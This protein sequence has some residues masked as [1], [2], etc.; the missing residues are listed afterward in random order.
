[1]GFGLWD[2]GFRF[3]A[4]PAVLLLCCTVA[5]GCGKK[6]P[7]LAPYVHIPEAVPKLAATRVGDQV[8]VTMTVPSHNIDASTPADVS[9]IEI[10]A[11]TANT[12]PPTPRFLELASP[13]AT[14][15]VIPAAEP[16]STAPSP[17]P[18]RSALGA[19]QGTAITVSDRLT[20]E[21]L[22][23]KILPAPAT[24]AGSAVAPPPAAPPGPLQRSY[25]ALAF[26]KGGRPGP[27]SRFDLPLTLL[28]EA[29]GGLDATYS[30]DMLTLSWQPSGGLLGFI[31]DRALPIEANPLNDP[32]L[33]PAPAP[34]PALQPVRKG[35][36][37]VAAAPSVVPPPP[38]L[39]LPAGPTRYFV[40]RDIEPD[41]LVLPQPGPKATA[42]EAEMPTPLNAAPLTTLTLTAPV[43]LERQQC[44]RVRAVRGVAP[45][46]VVGVASAPF[47]VRPV[48]IVPPAAP[49]GLSAVA[50]EGAISLIWEP[51]IEGDL[52]GYV[53]LRGEAGNATLQPLVATPV[54]DARYTDRTVEGGVRYVYAVVAVDNRV[55]VA[56][57]SAPSARVEET[58]R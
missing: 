7:P 47:C 40:Y 5:V 42:W 24:R 19:N 6:G 14:I 4:P 9:R 17:P 25:L 1:L 36:A 11:V 29:P 10:F 28:A 12:P 33:V 18:Q 43:E 45:N 53:I 55:P 37:P 38:P 41:P 51:N 26:S 50:A 35:S 58:A 2:L 21:A 49:T 57:A 46:L 23:P 44:Y 54:A 52:D 32:S 15:P 22:V 48:D 39:E 13:V 34:A 16:G 30:G 31:T 56:N 27:P 3:S 8:L 20:P